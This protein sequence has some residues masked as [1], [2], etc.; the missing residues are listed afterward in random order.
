M[1]LI[2]NSCVFDFEKVPTAKQIKEKVS[3]KENIPFDLVQLFRDGLKIQ[4]DLI[5]NDEEGQV[6]RSSMACA[7]GG[8]KGGFGAMLRSL[9]KQKGK[10]KFPQYPCKNVWPS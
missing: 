9:A 5:I 6:F 10:T 7:V 4:D 8:G 3:L 1:Q 2:V